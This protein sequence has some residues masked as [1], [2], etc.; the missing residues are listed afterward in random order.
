MNIRTLAA[1]LVAGISAAL[2][3]CAATGGPPPGFQLNAARQEG[4]AV[5]ALTLSGVA[6]KN[7]SDYRI[8]IRPVIPVGRDGVIA[9]RYFD[10]PARHAQW[11]A[12]G[13]PD[14]S[15]AGEAAVTVKG[16]GADSLPAIVADG[17]EVGRLASLR[18]P[19]GRYEIFDWSVRMPDHYG[20][21][22]YRPERGFSYPFTIKPGQ[23]VYAGQLNLD[24]TSSSGRLAVTDER[25]RDLALLA[26]TAPELPA[27]SV[28]IGALQP[29]SGG[30]P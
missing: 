24:L 10:S 27:A 7:V 9:R 16:P 29:F 21:L 19:P 17:V 8:R 11:A 13:L 4:L 30:K 18:L 5:V 15:P 23:A 3:G 6:M 25:V 12:T 1:L 26:K 20:G 2:S 22:E 28:E 14:P